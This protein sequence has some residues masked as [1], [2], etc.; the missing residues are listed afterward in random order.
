[1]N[2][3][4]LESSGRKNEV[5]EIGAITGDV[6][7]APGTLLANIGRGAGQELCHVGD[8]SSLNHLK[9]E[10]ETT[11]TICCEFFLSLSLLCEFCDFEH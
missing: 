10:N 1:M 8:C 9:R 11:D 2:K 5:A 7:K 6:A 4:N 3:I